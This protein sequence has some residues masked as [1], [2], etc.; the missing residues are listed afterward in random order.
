VPVAYPGLGAWRMME[1]A[2]IAGFSLDPAGFTGPR[3]PLR[4][5]SAGDLRETAMR[6]AMMRAPRVPYLKVRSDDRSTCPWRW[7]NLC[8]TGT[9]ASSGSMAPS[10]KMLA[11]DFESASFA[12]G[13]RPASVPSRG[14]HQAS[15]GVM[16]HGVA[17]SA[18]RP[19]LVED[20]TKTPVVGAGPLLRDHR[21]SGHD[22]AQR[23][24]PSSASCASGWQLEGSPSSLS[25]PARHSRP[26]SV[27]S[28]PAGS[29]SRVSAT[30]QV[31]PQRREEHEMRMRTL[32]SLLQVG[33]TWK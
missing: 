31:L 2:G 5:A 26:Q 27:A 23:L 12:S 19:P 18:R 9:C 22:A 10:Q 32:E 14:A 29:C 1:V 21:S 4:S 28:S 30:G 17:D 11:C 15:N 25:G 16:R 24:S 6:R 20:S 33:S 3:L 7:K 8:K 13:M